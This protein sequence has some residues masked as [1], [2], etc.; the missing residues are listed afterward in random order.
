MRQRHNRKGHVRLR[1]VPY[2]ACSPAQR[3]AWDALW[4]RLLGPVHP[5]ETA[6]PQARTLRL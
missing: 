5:P 1:E 2:E 3:A 4:Q 6:K